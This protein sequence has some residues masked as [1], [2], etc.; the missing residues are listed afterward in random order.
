MWL[1]GVLAKEAERGWERNARKG[2]KIFMKLSYRHLCSDTLDLHFPVL[3]IVGVMYSA[4]ISCS[5]EIVGHSCYLRKGNDTET[6]VSLL[7]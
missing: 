1:A 5:A 6:D 4:V 2:K 3:K 7:L